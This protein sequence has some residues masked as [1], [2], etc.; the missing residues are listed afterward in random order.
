MPRNQGP[1]AHDPFMPFLVW[2]M[3]SSSH[4]RTQLG[5][6]DETSAEV[7]LARNGRGLPLYS[8][9]NDWMASTPRLGPVLLYPESLDAGHRRENRANPSLLTRT[10]DKSHPKPPVNIQHCRRKWHVWTWK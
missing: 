2:N 4:S 8:H 1:L 10:E 5:T 6:H 9:L 7:C 3:N